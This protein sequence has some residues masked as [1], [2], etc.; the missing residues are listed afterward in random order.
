MEV[1]MRKMD[2]SISARNS[3]IET[4]PKFGKTVWIHSMLHQ[5]WSAFTMLQWGQVKTTEHMQLFNSTG[6][7]IFSHE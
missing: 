4:G 7:R 1:S 5:A 3:H 2:T 6:C